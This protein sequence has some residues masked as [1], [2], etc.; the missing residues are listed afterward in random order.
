MRGELGLEGLPVGVVGV[1]APAGT[2]DM[3]AT[4]FDEAFVVHDPNGHP[5]SSLPYSIDTTGGKHVA[6]T[7]AEGGTHRIPT[8][9]SEP[10]K[11]ALQWYTASTKK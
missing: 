9:A 5:I 3:Q 6:K 8:L 2:P 4:S 11:F 1:V 10:L 7:E